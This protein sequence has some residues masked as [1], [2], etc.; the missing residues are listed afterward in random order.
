[1][2]TAQY[3]KFRWFVL[4]A[5]VVV[6]ASTSSI[7]I[8]PAP[9]IPTIFQSMNWDPGATI[10]ATMLTFQFSVATCAL[11]S[12]VL[13]DKIGFVRTWI[14]GLIIVITGSLLELV[15]GNSINGVIVCRILNGVGTGPIM[16]CIASV[17]A[18][19]FAYKERTYVAAFQGFAVSSGIAIGLVFSPWMLQVTGNWQ[20]AL[21]FDSILPIIGLVFALVV[22]F[23]P[24]Q[25][26]LE[27]HVIASN[28]LN[29]KAADM[30]KVFLYGTFWILVLMDFID[31]WAQQ[32]YQDIAP[33]Y[34]AN[35][36]PIGLGFDPLTAGKMLAFASYAMM[37]GTLVA[38]ILTEKLF[39]GNAKPTVCIGLIVSAASVMA[40]RHLTQDSGALLILIPCS[41]LFFSSFV[42]PTIFGF[43]AKNYPS[44][45]TGK[46]GGLITG[47]G[48]YGAAIGVALGSYLR[49]T[50]NSYLPN[51]DVLCGLMIFGAIVVLFLRKPKGFE[52]K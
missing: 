25:E 45:I 32:A 6:T 4:V 41:I 11:L 2:M 7:L 15:I 27:E 42:N 22:Y 43:V 12:G 5:M 29:N 26:L 19:R 28:N 24:K 30:K 48:I 47:M 9:L 1:M 34:Y 21:A 18:Q 52:Q 33:V 46:I 14:I 38:P 3:S 39:K 37:A 13:I 44:H 50:T 36:A 10:A 35:P 31:S 49:S 23:G 17:C 20:K 51:M 40:V 16:A 8:S